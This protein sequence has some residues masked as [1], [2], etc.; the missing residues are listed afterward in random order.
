M[1]GD[2]MMKADLRPGWCLLQ[3][4]QTKMTKGEKGRIVSNVSTRLEREQQINYFQSNMDHVYPSNVYQTCLKLYHSPMFSLATPRFILESW[5]TA[6]TAALEENET[7]K[8]VSN[9]FGSS[10]TYSIINWQ[11][12]CIHKN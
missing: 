1:I 7:N 2:T 6:I 11:V 9:L 10:L 3:R 5:T 8:M 4:T 12:H